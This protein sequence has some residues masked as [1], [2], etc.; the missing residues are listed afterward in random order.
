MGYPAYPASPFPYGNPTP[1]YCGA[2]SGAYPPV[3][4]QAPQ[5]TLPGTA[6]TAERH[7]LNAHMLLTQA[8]ASLGS[9][10]QWNDINQFNTIMG[11]ATGDGLLTGGDNM[12]GAIDVMG[13]KRCVNQARTLVEAA[14]EE[15]QSANIMLDGRLL[16]VR[17]AL[18]EDNST[19]LLLCCDNIFTNMSERRKIEQSL[20][21]IQNMQAAVDQNLQLLRSGKLI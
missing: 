16:P 15:V 7:L 2:Q 4:Q 10:M 21:R 18:V 13:E 3:Q 14:Y 1:R 8:Q 12:L 9:S 5:T 11:T 19:M 17:M 20:Y 6:G